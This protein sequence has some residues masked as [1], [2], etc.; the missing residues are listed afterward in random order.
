[1]GISHHVKGEIMSNYYICSD[2]INGKE[3]SYINAL[4][5]ALKE[6]G[7]TAVS[8]GVGP[9]TV[10]SHGLGGSSSG[11]IG[12]FIVGGS[13]AGM[14]VDF[15]TG[16]R[17]GYYHYKMMWVVFA[18]NTATTD[19]WI[20]CNGLANT[21]LV[22][23]HDDNYSGSNIE[24]VG[25]TAKAYFDKNKQYIR[26]ACGKL[27]CTFDDVVQNFLAGGGMDSSDGGGETSASTIKDAIKEVMS[28]WDGEVECYVRENKMYIHKIKEP[29]EDCELL[30]SE[31]INIASD[32][33]TIT[34]YNPDT[35]NFLTVHWQGGEDIVYRDESLIARFGEKPL[36]LDAV[37]RVVS[38]DSSSSSGMKVS[39][40][41]VE[42][43]KTKNQTQEDTE[44]TET[45]NITG[46]AGDDTDTDVD[47]DTDTEEETTSNTT[48]EEVPVE[49]YEEA[50]AFANVE[51]AKIK[52]DDGHTLECKTAGGEKWDVG[53]WCRV[54]L[55]SFNVDQYMYISRSSQNETPDSGWDCSLTLTDY[56]PSLGEYKEPSND[57]ETEDEE[58]DESMDDTEIE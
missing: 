31:G 55:P 43:F 8:G 53:K 26:Y 23:A 14:Y 40:G 24:S 52:R 6:K 34:D 1:M 28:F 39:E 7:H 30:L 37:K 56:P 38:G 47:V 25:Q 48:Y 19:K 18:S 13:D 12:V 9:N 22:R 2:N 29:Q 49:T 46:A 27:G 32:S 33:V 41:L 21:P 11:Q 35:V 4:I 36:E 54:Y 20:T 42:K 17:N 58:L 45:T 51:W 5:N 3:T 50:V 10:Q 15:V 16:L 44:N 57:E